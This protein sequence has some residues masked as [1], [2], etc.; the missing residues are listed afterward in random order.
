MSAWKRGRGWT[1]RHGW[2]PEPLAR[3]I[4]RQ[5]REARRHVVVALPAATQDEIYCRMI[6]AERA[7]RETWTIYQSLPAT[8]PRSLF[9][10]ARD[11]WSRAAEMRADLLIST[12]LSAAYGASSS[13]IRAATSSALPRQ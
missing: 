1:E 8:A 13:A 9:D 11:T 6:E 10:E 4:G 2:G 5:R 7:E 3:L 12:R